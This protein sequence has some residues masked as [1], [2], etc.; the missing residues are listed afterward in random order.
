MLIILNNIIRFSKVVRLPLII[1]FSNLTIIMISLLLV[2]VLL[3]MLL[4][5]KII[6]SLVNHIAL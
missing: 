3:T 5:V 4:K 6:S 2:L 1:M